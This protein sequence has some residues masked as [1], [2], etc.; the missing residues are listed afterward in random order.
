M[1]TVPFQKITVPVIYPSKFGKDDTVRHQKGGLYS[2]VMLPSTLIIEETGE[3]AYAYRS[4]HD[5][6]VWVRSQKKM[7]DGRFQL[8]KAG[9]DEEEER[10]KREQAFDLLLLLGVILSVI[11]FGIYWKLW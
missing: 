5:S 3:P 1:T 11:L 6:R 7:E 10:K 9:R 2:I 8:V 4:H